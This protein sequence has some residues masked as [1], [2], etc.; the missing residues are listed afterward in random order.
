M[1]TNP[2]TLRSS[3]DR[4]LAAV[5][6]AQTSFLRPDP[7]ARAEAKSTDCY[8]ELIAIRDM[9]LEYLTELQ[10]NIQED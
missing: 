1:T 4:W 3:E 2:D 6:L 9:V 10:Q 5:A 8:P 7:E